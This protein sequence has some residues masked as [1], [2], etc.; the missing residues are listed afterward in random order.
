MFEAMHVTEKLYK[1]E[2]NINKMKNKR[3]GRIKE[4]QHAEYRE[5]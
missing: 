5:E 4:G 1:G 2:V 3:K